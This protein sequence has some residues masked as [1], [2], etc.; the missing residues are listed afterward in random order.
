MRPGGFPSS[1]RMQ[2]VLEANA[3][4]QLV[5]EINQL[6]S[7]D[8][9]FTWH[10]MED[11][12]LVTDWQHVRSMVD[13]LGSS[14]EMT[15]LTVV[16]TGDPVRFAQCCGD[17]ATGMVVEVSSPS[18]SDLVTRLHAKAWEGHL[19]TNLRW[20]YFAADEELHSPGAVMEIFFDWLV[21]SR[22]PA[23]MERRP[24]WGLVGDGSTD[25]L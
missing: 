5:T 20:A 9:L 24:V 1:K 3:S 18:G 10:T 7:F 19:I 17:V 11:E 22:I 6:L 21:H 23:G 2:G 8:A 16:K 25:R 4:A 14:F 13:L 12:G 15:F